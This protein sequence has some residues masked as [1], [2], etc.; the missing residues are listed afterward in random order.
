M[1][2]RREREREISREKDRDC[3]EGERG[4]EI[5][6]VKIDFFLVEIIII[7]PKLRDMEN[8]PTKCDLDLLF[9]L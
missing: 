8:T 5:F 3:G 7:L 6:L 9:A 1:W 4:R 2:R